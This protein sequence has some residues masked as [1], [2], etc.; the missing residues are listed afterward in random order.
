[1]NPG[2]LSNTIIERSVL[3]NISNRSS[4]LMNKPAM[5]IGPNAVYRVANTI[6]A[7]GGTIQGITDSVLMPVNFSEKKLKDVIKAIDYQCAIIGVNI[8]GGYTEVTDKV[9]APVVTVTG[10][11]RLRE[12]VAAK[13]G[14][15]WK[16][17]KPNQDIVMTKW[18]G[19]EGIRMIDS[20]KHDDI[21]TRYTEDIIDKALGAVED[22]CIQKE[23]DIVIDAGVDALAPVGK[24]GIFAALWNMSEYSG[25]GFNIDFKAIPVRQEI[26]E[27]CEMYDIN[28]YELSSAGSLL[29]TAD[30]G[31]DIVELLRA[32][33]INAV[34]IGKTTDNNDKLIVNDD[35][36]R[37]MDIPKR[38]EIYKV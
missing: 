16:N 7:A 4:L 23:A 14:L 22:I 20:V 35:E 34:V 31:C 13:S 33:G 37:Y 5:G 24:G 12:D 29:M 32:E 11:G 21:L 15:N 17:A 28:P 2:N 9:T 19:I 18:I 8:A 6:A 1:M 38:D 36:N 26:I 25:L 30:R 3:K 27:I 10:I